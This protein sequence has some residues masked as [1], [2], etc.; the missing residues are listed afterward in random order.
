MAHRAKGSPLGER[1][2]I[3][4]PGIVPPTRYCARGLRHPLDVV[5]G[6]APAAPGGGIGSFCPAGGGRFLQIPPKTCLFSR[7]VVKN[8]QKPTG[9][10]GGGRGWLS[11]SRE[12]CKIGS[13]GSPFVEKITDSLVPGIRAATGGDIYPR[14]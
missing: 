1:G 8:N 5:V 9:D 14:R 7:R 3:L 12:I 10:L 4:C 2:R 11:D 13:H 6:M